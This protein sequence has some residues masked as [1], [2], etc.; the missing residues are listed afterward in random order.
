MA[1]G[2]I[3][4]SW[5]EQKKIALN[6]READLIFYSVDGSNDTYGP[7][8]AGEVSCP[9]RPELIGIFRESAPPVYPGGWYTWVASRR[10]QFHEFA[11]QFCLFKSESSWAFFLFFLFLPTLHAHTHTKSYWT[12]WLFILKYPFRF[13][14]HIFNLLS[15]FSVRYLWWCGL[16]TLF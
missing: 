14:H 16:R 13:P 4:A 5:L 8:D 11:P 6:W 9:H 2:D 10:L 7:G 12:N 3:S 1:V 15:C